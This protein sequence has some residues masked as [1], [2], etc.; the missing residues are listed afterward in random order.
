MRTKGSNRTNCNR[1]DGSGVSCQID[2]LQR[3]SRLSFP[4]S[5]GLTYNIRVG[6]FMGEAG[7][8]EL[9]VQLDCN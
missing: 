2:G 9:R 6:G 3:K 5:A 7:N 1:D 8:F 4:C